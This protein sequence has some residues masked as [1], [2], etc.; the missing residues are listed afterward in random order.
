MRERFRTRHSARGDAFAVRAARQRRVRGG[1]AGPFRAARLGYVDARRRSSVDA[2][3][4]PLGVETGYEIR[5]ARERA[6]SSAFLG[7][8]SRRGRDRDEAGAEEQRG[9]RLRNRANGAVRARNGADR[10]RARSIAAPPTPAVSSALGVRDGGEEQEH[11]Q[12][13]N[14][15]GGEAAAVRKAHRWIPSLRSCLARRPKPTSCRTVI[16]LT[17]MA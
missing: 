8:T 9:A 14:E 4:R 12:D 15:S 7:A 13:Q 5:D 10:R 6:C 2:H 11:G 3:P 1:L 17:M 16:L